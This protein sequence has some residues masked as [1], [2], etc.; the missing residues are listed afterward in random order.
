M[1]CI[2]PLIVWVEKQNQ[3]IP[4]ECGRCPECIKKRIS[5]WSFRLRQEGEV[6]SSSY[7]ITLTYDTHH[8]PITPK[9]FMTLK[10]ED[11][12][13]WLKRLRKI[14]K[15]KIKYFYVGEYGKQNERPHYHMIIF[16]AD[17]EDIEKTWKEG[18]VQYGTVTGASIGYTL[19]YMIKDGII[20]K[21][22]NDDRLK[23]F[24]RMSKGIGLSYLTAETMYWHSN[25][26][27]LLERL[28][29][30]ID[31]KKIPMPRY[32][33]ERIYDKYHKYLIKNEA[34]RL[35][36]KNLAEREKNVDLYKE[37]EAQ[38]AAFEKMLKSKYKNKHL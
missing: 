29:C 4:V 26:Y 12:T 9:G 18:G 21:H 8:V 10:P 24:G 27:T 17:I 34:I 14:S 28:C 36:E 38:K 33:K 11:V 35:E 15:E 2:T 32:Y 13:L 30:N 3:S 31:G 5:Q 7:F 19:K 22:K 23:E 37:I 16:N 25:R 20:P 1:K 6:S